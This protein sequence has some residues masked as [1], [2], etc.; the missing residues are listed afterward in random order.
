[1]IDLLLNIPFQLGLI[2]GLVMIVL[3]FN[4]SLRQQILLGSPVALYSPEQYRIEKIKAQEQKLKVPF[5]RPGEYAP[6]LAW[7]LYTLRQAGEDKKHVRQNLLAF[8]KRLWRWPVDTFFRGRGSVRPWVWWTFFIPVTYCVL[9]FCWAS[10]LASW[11]AYWVYWTLLTLFQVTDRTVIATLRGQLRTWEASRREARHAHAACMNCLHV[12]D[13]PAYECPGPGCTQLHYDVMPGDLGTLYR[14]CGACGTTFPTLPSRAA[15]VAQA[16][17]KR[18]ECHQPLPDGAGAVRDIRVPVFGDVAAG[19]TRY[20]G[21]SLNSLLADLDNARIKYDYLDAA[22]RDEAERRL[23]AI[24]ANAEMPKTLEGPA[25]AINLRVRE[26]KQSDLIHLFD[27]AGEQYSKPGNWDFENV[28]RGTNRDSL[29]FLEDGQGLAYVLD[30][31]SVDRIRDL[32]ANYDQAVIAEAHP[33]QKDPELSYTEVVNRLRGFG[34]QVKAQRLAVVVSKVD[35]LRKAG[36][37]VPTTSA[38]IAGWLADNGVHNL[39]M[40]APQEFAEVRFFAVASTDAAPGRADDPGVPLR[41]LLA[42]HGV[43]VPGGDALLAKAS[44]SREPVGV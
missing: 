40:A 42:V 25:T 23:K 5:P 11:A 35:L 9:T 12:T 34:A 36:I 2:F 7:P 8:Q 18:K 27:A 30:P 26:G 22:S 43:K 38:G 21:A 29:R 17:C 16:I 1:M 6:D 13:W 3:T 10:F 31:F 33:A 15:W 19:K 37:D 20:L 14:K 32:V 4:T 28:G 24:R 39:V 44:G 41:W